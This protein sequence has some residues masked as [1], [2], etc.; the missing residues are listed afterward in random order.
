MS[1]PEHKL[2]PESIRTSTTAGHITAAVYEVASQP[3]IV[4]GVYG[5]SDSSDR[6][7]LQVMEDLRSILRELTHVY[8]TQRILV[9]GDFNVGIEEEDTNSGTIKK[10]LTTALLQTVI[11]D[12]HLIDIGAQLNNRSHTWYRKDA[13]GQSSRIDYLLSSV[14]IGSATFKTTFSIFDHTY[15]EATLNIVKQHKQMTMKDFILGTDEYIIRSQ[16]YLLETLAPYRDP[17]DP[18]SPRTASPGSQDSNDSAGPHTGREGHG[19][20]DDNIMVDGKEQGITSL[21]LFNTTIQDLQQLHDRIAKDKQRVAGKKLRETSAEIFNL[22]KQLRK[23]GLPETKQDLADRITHLQHELSAQLEAR[24]T[25]STMRIRDFYKTTTGKMK[26][27]TFHCIKEGNRSR[28]IHKLEHEGRTVTDPE[29]IITIMQQWYE[30]TAERLVPQAETLYDFLD[31]HQIELPQIDDDQKAM[32]EEEFTMQ[33]V[34]QAIQEANEVSAPGPSGQTIAFFKLLFLAIPAVMT[35]ALNQLVFVPHLQEAED[36]RW[37]RHR[38]VVYIPKISQPATPSDYRPLSMLEVLY[39]IPSRIL[40]ARLSR[41]LPTIIGPHQHGFMAQRGIQEPSL[42]ATHLIQDAVHYSKPLQLVSFDMEK[43]F[44]RVGHKIIVQALRAFGVPEIM[45]M[46]IQHYTLVG[47]AYVEVNGRAGILIT[48][49]TG[50]GQGDPLSS[51]LFLIA[52]EPLNRILASNFQGLMYCTEEGVTVGPLLYADDNLTP[53]ALTEAD[54]LQPILSLYDEYTGVS[55]LNINIAKTTALCVNSSEQLCERL[56]HMGMATPDNAK[57]LGILLG[58]TMDSTVEVTMAAIEPKLIKR[59]ILAT[60]PPTD[61]LHRATLVTTALIPVYNHVFMALPVEPRHTESL[62]SEILRFLW[63]KQVDGNT[64]QKRRLV[65]KRRISAGIEM[66]GLGIQHPDEIIQ[67]FQLNLLQ[68]IHRQGR[69]NPALNLPTILSGLLT[70]ANR[71]SL[72][73]HIHHLGPKQWRITGQR[74]LPWNRLLGLAFQSVATLLASSETTRDLWHTAAV[75][76]HSNF[77]KVFPLTHAEGRL[78]VERGILTVSQLLEVNDL[79]GRLSTDENRALFEDLTA[80]P[81]LQHKLRLFVRNFRRAPIADKM[82]CPITAGSSFF[83]VDKNLS[84]IFRRQLRHQLHKKMDMPPSYLTRQ[85][86]GVM[87]PRRDTFLNA[88]KVLSMSLL[89]SKTKETTFQILNR[90]V[91]TQNKAFKSGMAAEPTC[92]RCEEV[93]TMEHLLY[94]C[95]NYSAKI[96][97]LAS[98]VLTLSLSRHSGDFIPRIDLTPLEIVFNKPHPS[99]LLHVPDGTTRKIL[100][101]FIQEI[102]RD[103]I[104]RRA[105]LAEPR[106]R[107]ELLPRIRAHLL[108]VISKLQSFME[109]Q[110]VLNFADALALLR[111]MDHSTLHD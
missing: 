55:G 5:H 100:I 40:A 107:E 54:Q 41:I 37:I 101:L 34:K 38:K 79:T 44:D 43:A 66:G 67:G 97:A 71:P 13:S 32:L 2:I 87:L 59:R 85:R 94:G 52:T 45:I 99:I 12:Y 16:D 51:I 27:E 95:E 33:E 29:E 102:K 53:L 98:K 74:L 23:P 36:F 14:P 8:E 62:F 24:D 110:G 21:H 39:K 47:F 108:S 11:Q 25:A 9:A 70:R 83:L 86:D 56:R 73:D 49:K 104:F 68:K 42:L 22:K 50:S 1:R 61:V 105:Q 93:E 81:H 60:T 90:T 92:L 58:K 35:A 96:W 26:P 72:A 48:I 111:R 28:A 91:W 103:I 106:R 64:K 57:H 17:R 6:A 15:L 30:K 78:L 80:F 65:A 82:S 76:G 31:R 3:T 109:Y 46:A 20:L 75:H 18:P 84:Q 69:T 88:Y 63:T 4:V 89:P 10:P 77:S 19:A 7:S